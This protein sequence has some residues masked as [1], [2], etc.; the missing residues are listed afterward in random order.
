VKIKSAMAFQASSITRPSTQRAAAASLVRML[1]VGMLLGGM[2]LVAKLLVGM[3]LGGMLLGGVLAGAQQPAGALPHGD[4]KLWADA[5]V[6]NELGIINSEGNFPVRFRERK[7]DT[8]GDTTREVIETQ[9][10]TVARLVQ[11][12]GQPLT[13]DEDAAERDRLNSDAASP[14]QFMRHH[15][16][17]NTTRDS[18]LQ[19]VRMMPQAMVFSYAPGQPQPKGLTA[20]QIVLDFRPDPAFKAPTVAADLLTGVEGR[21]WVDAQT[22]CMTRVEAKILHPINFGFGFLA[23]LYPGGTVEFEQGPAGGDRW[24]YRHV[25]E[26]VTVRALM[27]KT[28]PVNVEMTSWDFRLMPSPVPYQEAIKMLLA[29][30]ISLR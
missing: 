7:I 21:V 18:V 29:M 28:L 16:R 25:E 23:R 10:G 5:A 13:A 9:Q 15:K 3:L 26:H 4:P 17:D 24:V 14:E 20:T 30:P 12:N 19:L 11:R 8:K 22:Q 2:L 6:R 27:V 1:Q